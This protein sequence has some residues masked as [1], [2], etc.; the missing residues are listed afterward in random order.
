MSSAVSNLGISRI[1]SSDDRKTVMTIRLAVLRSAAGIVAVSPRGD[2]K[3]P[4]TPVDFQCLRDDQRSGPRGRRRERRCGRW[5][6]HSGRVVR[7]PERARRFRVGPPKNPVASAELRRPVSPN[8]PRLS[9][10]RAHLTLRRW[11]QS[12]R[13]GPARDRP[14]SARPVANGCRS[15]HAPEN[16]ANL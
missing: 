14:P 15:T 1:L 13:A 12:G 5:R 11:T 6:S 16:C 8:R 2:R 4:F 3:K 10:M 7:R 9:W